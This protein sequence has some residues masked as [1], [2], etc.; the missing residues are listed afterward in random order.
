MEQK[1][2]K[3][4]EFVCIDCFP[5]LYLRQDGIAVKDILGAGHNH[6]RGDD[7]GF[8][9]HSNRHRRR[10]SENKRPRDSPR[11][12]SERELPLHHG[13]LHRVLPHRPGSRLRRRPVGMHHQPGNSEETDRLRSGV[14]QFLPLL[15]PHSPKPEAGNQPAQQHGTKR[16]TQSGHRPGLPQIRVVWI[17]HWVR[18]GVLVLDAVDSGFHSGEVGII[19]LWRETRIRAGDSTDIRGVCACGLCEHSHIRFLLCGDKQ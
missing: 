14:V 3:I 13:N 17:R 18:D 2:G 8:H 6:R 12:N 19:F 4:T 15:I 16:P 1:I 9:G 7:G 5:L 10:S 11:R